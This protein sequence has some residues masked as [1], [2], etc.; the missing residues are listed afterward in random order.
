MGLRRDKA[1][2][3][4]HTELAEHFAKSAQ[5]Y[6][7]GTPEHGHLTGAAKI[8]IDG[9]KACAKSAVADELQKTREARDAA[10]VVHPKGLSTVA[11][12]EPNRAIPRTGQPNTI[13]VIA[14]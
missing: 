7:E 12:P 4:M 6:D 5:N 14:N 8:L 3:A 13:P 10:V 2:D 9:V 11:P 1:V